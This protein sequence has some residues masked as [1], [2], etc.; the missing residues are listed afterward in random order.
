MSLVHHRLT[1]PHLARREGV[2]LALRTRFWAFG[3]SMFNLAMGL[4]IL[5]DRSS[6]ER[7]VFRIHR[8]TFPLTGWVCF[9][10]LV[11]CLGLLTVATKS[12]RIWL[13]TSILAVMLSSCWALCLLIARILGEFVP[14]SALAIWGFIFFSYFMG[15]A[16]PQQLDGR[17]NRGDQHCR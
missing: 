2:Q 4:N 1:L 7:E 3:L 8:E 13:I 9:W 17:F 15:M 12:A 5:A 6:Y 11:S 10:L 14:T 16:S